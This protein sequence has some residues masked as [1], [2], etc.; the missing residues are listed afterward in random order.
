MLSM[1]LIARSA[2]ASG[3]PGLNMC[4]RLLT[5]MVKI[6]GEGSTLHSIIAV[7]VFFQ[8]RISGLNLVM[9]KKQN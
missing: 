9:L 3:A 6:T 2:F 8:P 1:L 4:I 7:K 5:L